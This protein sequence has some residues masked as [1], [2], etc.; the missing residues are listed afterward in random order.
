MI[1]LL[2]IKKNN[3]ILIGLSPF[4]PSKVRDLLF[5]FLFETCC[6][7]NAYITDSVSSTHYALGRTTGLITNLGGL[8]LIKLIFKK[9]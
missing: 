9:L 7:D 6:F 8:F 4:I 3:P 1:N 2:N 5:Q